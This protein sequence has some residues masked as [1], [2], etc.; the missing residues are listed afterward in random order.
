M[1]KS[2]FDS[3]EAALVSSHSRNLEEFQTEIEKIQS[4]FKRTIFK[5]EKPEGGEFPELVVTIPDSWD[6][7]ILAPFYDV[8]IGSRE[9]DSKLFRKHLEWVRR[10]PHVICFLGGDMYD[11]ITPQ[12]AQKMGQ[13]AMSPAEQH[14]EATKIFA[15]IRHKVAFTLCG[16]HEA[17]SMRASGIDSAKQLADNLR[18]PYFPDYAF[19]TIR[20]RGLKFRLQAHHG[21]GAARTAGAQRN[22]ARKDLA[23]TKADIIWTGHLHKALCD[24][25][26]SVDH[27][28]ETG[29]LVERNAAVLISPA[30]LRYFGGYGAA[31]RMAPDTRGMTVC[32]LRDNGRI[33]VNM[34]ARGVRK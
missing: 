5:L 24:I 6:K 31:H 16:N 25:V 21:S 22:A 9:H 4:R 8:H 26:Y 17:R 3:L 23:W 29:R 7:V 12:Q 27:D 2:V 13:N 19:V 10:T 14:W 11:N 33:D 20:W 28:P 32:T 18:V 30:Y 15:P 34:H 1:T